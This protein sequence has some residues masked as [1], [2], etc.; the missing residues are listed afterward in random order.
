MENEAV[1]MVGGRISVN[2]CLEI[3]NPVHTVNPLMPT[4]CTVP[5]QLRCF[6]LYYHDY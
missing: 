2:V 6:N 5:R 4:Y 1:D 3:L